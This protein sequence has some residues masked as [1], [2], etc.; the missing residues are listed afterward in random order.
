M[1][2]SEIINKI[3]TLGIIYLLAGW[4]FES[5]RKY[6][7]FFIPTVQL[8]FLVN[9]NQCLMTQL[10]KYYL[11]QERETKDKEIIYDSFVEQKLKEWNIKINPKYREYL[12]NSGLYCSFLISY[13]FM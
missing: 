2:N 6:L 8:Q 12:I 5:Q 1:K 13:F 11:V 10:E 7:I 4:T 9:N 3:H